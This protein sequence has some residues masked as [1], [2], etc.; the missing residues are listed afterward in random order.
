MKN[1][2]N[3]LTADNQSKLVEFTNDL[4]N[5]NDIK[6]LLNKWYYNKLIPKTH[7]KVYSIDALKVYLIERKTK[8]L[9]KNL[10]KQIERINTI[11]NGIDFETIKINVEWK[12]SYMWG[13]NPRAEAR[14]EYKDN[15]CNYFD[16]GSIGGCGYDKL[17]TAIANSLNQVN[18]L[19]KL[20]YQLKNDN[21]EVN[22]HEF[23]GYGSG[24]GLLPSFEGGVGV[25]CYNK[26]FNKLGYKFE[27]YTS[28]KSFDVFQI[29]KL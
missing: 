2:I 6:E 3:K 16:S 25:S 12:K 7:K 20:M 22:N 29:T 8:Q 4:N 26:I 13:S 21:I 10:A 17:S 14:V 23:F 24:Y 15:S 19:L 5:I 1:L 11:S 9:N 18:G 28:G 27:Q